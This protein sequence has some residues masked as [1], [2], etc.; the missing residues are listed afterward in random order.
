[1]TSFPL[2][3][4]PVVALALLVGAGCDRGAASPA[5][6]TPLGPE[7]EAKLAAAKTPQERQFLLRQRNMTD[8]QKA[9][10]VKQQASPTR[11]K[12]RR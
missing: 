5:G 1:L 7:L 11:Q 12:K 6:Q 3:A 2:V 9:A 10:L 8:E 4:I